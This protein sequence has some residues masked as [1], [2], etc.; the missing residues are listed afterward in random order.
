MGLRSACFC[1]QRTTDGVRYMCARRG[2]QVVNYIDDFAG[3]DTPALAWY[4][5]NTLTKILSLC[6]LLESP[7]K[8]CEPATVITFLGV[9]FN[10]ISMTLEVTSDRMHDILCLLKVWV[11]KK[12]ASKKEV[13][14]LVGKLVFV[15]SCVRPG[16]IFISRMLNFLREMPDETT[17]SLPIEFYKDVIWWQVFLPI[18]NGV[19]MMAYKECECP[20]FVAASDACL[21]GCG[22]FCE[23]EYFH[24]EFPEFILN[25]TL[26]INALE[27]L[28]IVICAKIW[29][30]KWKG[31]EVIFNCDNLTS[32]TVLNSGRSRDPF[33]Q[34]CL[35]EICFLAAKCEFLIKGNHIAGIENRI[36]DSLS[37]W[38]LNDS[39]KYMFEDLVSSWKDKKEINVSDNLF[40]FTHDW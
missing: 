18:Y 10:S 27:L 13:Q 19:S 15:A 1:C 37:R 11:D 31:K 4:R 23:N 38:H 29:G 14:S 34:Q 32:V 26:H 24:K 5:Y 21:S 16:R 40:N 2:C 20:D 25:K 9:L 6:G 33:L 3:A 28:S 12:L 30:P 35:R 8:S 36:P 17:L 39:F 7:A 22:G